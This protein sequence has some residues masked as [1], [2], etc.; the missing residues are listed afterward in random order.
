MDTEQEEP[1]CLLR[2]SWDAAEPTI[3]VE[4]LVR[5]ITYCRWAG[6]ASAID[7]HPMY[8]WPV[9]PDIAAAT[10]VQGGVARLRR[11]SAPGLRAAPLTPRTS[12]R[13]AADVILGRR[14][15]QRF[16]SG[17]SLDRN[18]LFGLLECVM[19]GAPGVLAQAHRIDLVLFLRRV[20]GIDPGVYLL[21][22]PGERPSLAARLAS[23]F[24][25]VAVADAPSAIDLRRIA[26]VG[27]RNL[28]RLARE[29]CC[30]QEIAAQAC[31]V[32]GLVAEFDAVIEQ[33]PSAYRSLHRE[34]G[35]LGHVLYLE[36]EARG[37]RGTGIGCFVDDAVHELLRLPDSRFQTLYHFA[38]GKAIGDTRIQT[39]PTRCPGLGER[40]G[41]MR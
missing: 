8:R 1:E 39:T 21:T 26:L 20:D 28:A 25:L 4:D 18:D 10:R 15:A 17:F 23:H 16:D 33:D 2:L 30:R 9:L 3:D 29:L 31:F 7:P 35:L 27:E 22:R 6:V 38:V 5:T 40:H 34:A 12:T 37:L 11:P 36:A 13:S 19:F 24:D 41:V 32:A 14:S